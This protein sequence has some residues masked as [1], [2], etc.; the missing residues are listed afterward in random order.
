MRDWNKGLLEVLNPTEGQFLYM[1]DLFSKE[2]LTEYMS[3]RW[4]Y[5]FNYRMTEK[6]WEQYRRE[7]ELLELDSW[8]VTSQ[9]NDYGTI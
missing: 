6:D 5:K 7:I 3:C 1:R 8:E 9:M 2:R 4:E